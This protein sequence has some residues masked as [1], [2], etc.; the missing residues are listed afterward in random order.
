MPTDLPK[1]PQTFAVSRTHLATAAKLA[2]RLHKARFRADGDED[3]L[4]VGPEV[5]R[6]EIA[7]EFR[8]ELYAEEV[9]NAGRIA[10]IEISGMLMRGCKGYEQWGFC[11]Y[12]VVADAIQDADNDDN[13]DRIV[14]IVDSPGGSVMGAPECAAAIAGVNKPLL[15]FTSGM[16]C[17]AAYWITCSADMIVATPSSSVG[18]I[19]VY[20]PFYDTSGAM[21]QM[22]VD[23]QVFSSGEQKGAGF[24]GTSLTDAQAQ[25]IQQDVNAIAADF[26]GEV[27]THRPQVDLSLFDGRDVS[28]K[29]AER[30]GLVDSLANDFVGAVSQFLAVY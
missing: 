19:G 4:E 23:V 24:P 20:S 1:T 5:D 10:I 29:E 11:D 25:R 28:G 27:L 26:Q 18:S 6:E 21:E 14:L 30:L 2:E 16:L 22:G 12:A 9:L 3:E 7:E 13:I 15:V 17:S 8:E